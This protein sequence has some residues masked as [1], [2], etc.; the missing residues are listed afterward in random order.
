MAQHNVLDNN[1][2]RQIVNSINGKHFTTITVVN[3]LNSNFRG[4]YDEMKRNSPRNFQAVIG[5]A[6][7]RYSI[8][9]NEIK[10]ISPSDESPA[11]WEKL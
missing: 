7:K 5:K 6:V 2:I 11:R 4:I 9:T 10:Q 8:E 3:I 1:T